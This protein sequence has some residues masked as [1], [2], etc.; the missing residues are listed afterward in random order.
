MLALEEVETAIVIEGDTSL[1]ASNCAIW[2]NSVAK[3]SLVFTDGITRAKYFCTAGRASIGTNASVS[4]RPDEN[5]SP[6]PDPLAGVDFPANSAC[7][8]INVK[9]DRSG[10]EYLKSGTYCGGLRLKSDDVSFSPGIY[11]IE[12]G[13]LDID[14]KGDIDLE[15]V[16]FLF[17]GKFEGMRIKGSSSINLVAPT[18]GA[19]AGVVFAQRPSLDVTGAKIKTNKDGK[20]LGEAIIDGKLNAEG[21]IYLPNFDLSLRRTGGGTT[22][23]PYLQMVVNTLSMSGDATLDIDFNA[24]QTNLPIIIKPERYAR[25][26]E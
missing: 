23:S 26:V 17:D 10:T 18:T 25:L 21:V 11:Y 22:K 16:T 6:I 19:T 7:D 12:G 8:Y 2:S 14:V 1:T 24:E 15:G 5:C 20:K 4:P 9:T 13:A 3:D